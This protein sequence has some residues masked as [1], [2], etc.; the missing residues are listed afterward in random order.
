MP[1]KPR[2]SKP[3]LGLRRSVDFSI[4]IV[5]VRSLLT[6]KTAPPPSRAWLP[7][8]R[9]PASSTRNVVAVRVHGAAR[10]AAGR[11]RARG[12]GAAADGAV[13]GEDAVVDRPRDADA[14]QRGA[15]AADARA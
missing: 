8:I 7:V 2:V 1:G 14:A 15:V 10:A 11:A 13:A 5:P 3:S 9:V 6:K 4:F 12:V